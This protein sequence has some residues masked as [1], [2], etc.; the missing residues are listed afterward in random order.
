MIGRRNISLQTT[1]WA[2]N[3]MVSTGDLMEV[4]AWDEC[5]DNRNGKVRKTSTKELAAGEK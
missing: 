2:L 1:W 3:V 4:V 5:S